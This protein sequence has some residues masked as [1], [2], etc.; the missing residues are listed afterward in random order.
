MDD[1]ALQ[2][3][4]GNAGWVTMC[5]S[6]GKPGITMEHSS[7]ISILISKTNWKPSLSIF[8]GKGTTSTML[9]VHGLWCI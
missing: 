1:W 4:E 3:S 9:L 5:Y 8:P 7:E 2:T 6:A